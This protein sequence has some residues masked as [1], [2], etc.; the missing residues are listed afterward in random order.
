MKYRIATVLS[1][2]FLMAAMPHQAVA[3][4]TS[5]TNGKY[6]RLHS[7]AYPE[8]SM[9]GSGSVVAGTTDTPASYAQTWK[10][11]MSGS[12]VALQNL[13]TLEYI[14]TN[15]GTSTQFVTGS[16]AK[17]F[18][19]TTSDGKM[20][21]YTSGYSYSALHC[22]ASQSYFVVGWTVNDSEA[23]WWNVEEITLTSAQETELAEIRN[24]N[25]NASS[26]TNSL[27]TFFSDYACTSLKSNYASMTDAQLRSAMSA[28]PSAV[29]EMA[30]RVKNSKWNTD[31]TWN[32]Y[33][34]NFR[35]ADYEIYSNC[36]L[37]YNK[38]KIG[39]FAHLFNPTG[40]VCSVGDV[41][42]LYV[43]ADPKDTDATLQVE[44]VVGTNRRGA[45]TTLK[46][47]FN[48]LYVTYDCELF[49]SYILNNVDKSCD[50]Y[51]NIK[52]H[53]EGGTCNGY[54][55]MHRGHTNS[56][57]AWLKANMFQ[58]KYLHVKGNSVLLNVL[59]S[60][61]VGEAKPVEV[62][63]V[64]DFIFDTEQSLSGCDQY[65]ST[66]KY[67]MMVNCF[68]N[69]DGGNP[70]W[71]DGNNGSSHP[72]LSSWSI[73][74]SSKL[75][76]FDTDGGQIWEIAH[77]LG[78]G[79]QNP[80]NLAGQTESS[81][82]SLCQC[83]T[84]LAA[85]HPEI[86]T[87][88]R[89][90]RGDG[91]KALIDR[92]NNG[93]S[94]I[95]LGSMR[96]QN[97]T[98]NDVWL[99]NKL[100]FQ[101]WLY[102]DYLKNY[103]GDANTGYSFMTALYEKM[104]ASGLS[105]SASSSNPGLASKDWLL[106]AQYASEIT[107]TD[108]TEFFQVWG[109]W[110]L[111]PTVSVE[112][113][114][115]STSTWFMG[116]Y[117]GYYVRT[118]ESYVTSVK[119]KMKQYSKKASNIMFIEDRCTG[120]TLKTYNGASV[121]SFGEMGYYGTY[122]TAVSGTYGYAVS[123]TTVRMTGGS[124]A[125]GFKIYDD[126]G[127]L[128]AISNTN[129][130][131]VN[132]T[133]ANGL[134]TGNYRIVAA[135]GDG[136]DVVAV[137]STSKKVT[138]VLKYDGKEVGRTENVMV[139][140]GANSEVNMPD[141]LKAV[142]GCG[143]WMTYTY[144]P[145]TI[146]NSTTT[147]TV[148]AT[149]NGPIP[150]SDSYDQISTWHMLRIRGD[151]Y[152]VGYAT[153]DGSATPNVKLPNANPET[154]NALWALVGNPYDGFTIYNK[155]AGRNL[156]LVSDNPLGDGNTGGNTY[157]TMQASG[158]CQLWFMEHSRSLPGY[159]DEGFYL[160]NADGYGL[161]LRSNDNL[162]YWIDGKDIGSTFT[163]HDGPVQVTGIEMDMT[164]AYT[165]H[166]VSRGYLAVKTGGTQMVGNQDKHNVSN[167]ITYADGDT[168]FHFAIVTS[169]RKTYLY[170]IGAEKFVSY[171]GEL[172]SS[173][174]D[175]DVIVVEN[176][177][178]TVEGY[179]YGIRFYKGTA[180]AVLCVNLGG[181]HQLTIDSWGATYGT[182]GEDGNAWAFEE[183][184][185][186]D[187]SY[188][189][190]LLNP[191]LQV[192]YNLV[193]NGQI[194]RTTTQG[195]AIGSQPDATEI[196]GWTNEYVTFSYSP[197]TI[198]AN[199]QTVTVTAQWNGPF[200]VSD[201]YASAKWYVMRLKDSYYPTYVSDANP[202]VTLPTAATD[203]DTQR[204]A[205]LGN[206]Y[207]GFTLIN[208]AAGA[209]LKLVSDDPSGDGNTGGNTYATLQVSGS[210]E[211]WKVVSSTYATNGF[212]IYNATNN[213]ALNQ[214]STEN[215]AYWTGSADRGSTFVVE[216]VPSD[217]AE[218]VVT[219]FGPFMATA[220]QYFSISTETKAN[221]QPMY[222]SYSVAPT[223]EAE[224]LEL[225]AVI[226]SAGYKVPS[227]GR[228]RIKSTRGRYMTSQN[229]TVAVTTDD[230]TD[231][232]TVITLTGEYPNFTITIGNRHFQAFEEHSQPGVLSEEAGNV[233][234][235]AFVKPGYCTIWNHGENAYNWLYM[236][237][238]ANYDIVGWYPDAEASWWQLEDAALLG[239]VNND[240]SV[241]I[242]DVTALVN[243]IITGSSQY[244]LQVV[245]ID[246][247]SQLTL[248]DVTMLVNMIL[249]PS[250]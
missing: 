54:F 226:E 33:E 24:L 16:V 37:W 44:T 96:T 2:L 94:W 76:N 6:Y 122:D 229:E 248:D 221:L 139:V 120:S 12:T 169:N 123:G 213:Y 184:G 235:F 173:P 45:A 197:A 156:K 165:I 4:V 42:Y 130:F 108:L 90:S 1:L 98:Y 41:V 212:F 158:T 49:I 167:Q 111:S 147:V 99:S 3:Y 61:V 50:D 230:A 65:K 71:G 21:F 29:Q 214:R 93:Y 78:H 160:S 163:I 236:H 216:E 23:S 179:P 109:F 227:A 246:G 174:T 190:S 95:D 132:S 247:N 140:P 194:V 124:G 152:N 100:I 47:G 51:A 9:D 116:D 206:P 121:E 106:L 112:N 219:D 26:Y 200:Q 231:L 89:S 7:A 242:A 134:A 196:E 189:L 14:Q 223:T 91:V 198:T 75:M 177:T 172:T 83:V 171:T 153:Y 238:R 150:I 202:N 32:T 53:I 159:E 193:F 222:D 129:T 40:I 133:I 181:S 17:Y 188:A 101:L 18:T 43:D 79:H 151:D 82:N 137:A 59:R 36:D 135:Q 191:D 84:V 39:R 105:H 38:L 250:L 56:D 60:N 127:N 182:F 28:L 215:L 113:D 114:I 244:D 52:I 155:A 5:L 161:N 25:A 86:F 138:Y 175:D 73:F 67:K 203:D 58:D 239:D 128:V 187:P 237:E 88:V 87:S 69:E 68:H 249:A 85:D 30:V 157:A 207:D 143:D 204:W 55:D 46:K 144:S 224:Y 74:N 57:W 208:K 234:I 176:T 22:A 225:K 162:A 64:W 154:D 209:D 72:D 102:F 103:L 119:N 211:L 136:S 20:A 220:G 199:T 142:G 15:P 118:A 217:W 148:T 245:D 195:A 131:T 48:A 168:Q 63:K 77:E 149:Y 241:N 19:T 201:D 185:D 164:K 170:S 66:G 11:V 31:A 186:F 34:Q 104:R 166:T 115:A 35:I 10:A 145:L 117:Q 107:Q 110:E 183:A 70:H 126:N 233:T 125:V 180:E 178:T 81:N 232:N 146:T 210:N 27:Q 80:I 141:V 97:G 192:T 62:M 243:L 13:L 205:F 218:R 92:F 8:L 228:Y 240:G